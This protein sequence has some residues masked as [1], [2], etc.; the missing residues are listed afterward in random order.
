MAGI[1]VSEA[2]L[3]V[4][5]HDSDLDQQFP[6]T[7]AGCHWL[8]NWLRRQAV[9]RAVFETIGQYNPELHQWLFDSG[10]G[11]LMVNARL[12]DRGTLEAYWESVK[13]GAWTR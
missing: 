11:A 2:G 4:Q 3:D 8:R 7:K 10:I 9:M 1:D 12:P 5:V 6:N 13:N